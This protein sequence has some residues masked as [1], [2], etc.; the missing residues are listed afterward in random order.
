MVATIPE[1][2][3]RRVS[4]AARVTVIPAPFGEIELLEA[5]WWNPARITDPAL[6]WLRGVLC[7]V[8]ASL[9]AEPVSADRPG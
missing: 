5:A 1:R 2:L 4:Q 8:A 3:A 9:S 7:E 6:S